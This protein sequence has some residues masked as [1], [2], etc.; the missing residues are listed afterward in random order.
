MKISTSH[1]DLLRRYLLWAYKTTKESFER[2]E[3]KTT[4]LMVDEYILKVLNGMPKIEAPRAEHLKRSTRCEA[5]VHKDYQ[6]LIEEFEQYIARKKEDE[7]KQKFSNG[8]RRALHPQYIYLERRLLAIE[9]AV[10]Y[11]LGPDML[12]TMKELYEKEFTNRILQA[13]EHT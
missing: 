5:A 13:R 6:K 1:K 10:K 8:S 11:F 2:I 9:E 4:Q 12:K 7:V 3:R